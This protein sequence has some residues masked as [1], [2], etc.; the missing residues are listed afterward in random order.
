MPSISHSEVSQ[1]TTCRRKHLYGYGRSLK[2]VSVAKALAYGSA[3]HKVLEA[4]YNTVLEAGK[5]LKQQQKAHAAGV[6]A[7]LEAWD[8]LKDFRQPDNRADL[9]ELLFDVYFPNE[10]IVGEGHRIVAVEQKYSLRYDEENDL[11]FPFVV[12]LVVIDPEGRTVIVDHKFVYDFYS[13]EATQLMGQIPK[14][15]GA[16]RALNHKV[17]YGAY[18]ELRSRKLKN[19]SAEMSMDFLPVRPNNTRVQNTFL[20]QI[21]TASE[22]Q[23]LKTLTEDE[24]E[25]LAFRVDNKMVCN[26]CD[27]KSLCVAEQEGA[28]TKLLLATEFEERQRG[29]EFEVS[30]DA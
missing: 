12:D 3:G 2:P 26:F 9:H 22:I 23:N 6:D 8:N 28:S 30:E 29:E 1:Y 13:I 25:R 24:R 18:N 20:E 21:R 11:R 15:I 5:T 10:A 27:F 17:D 16:L 7:A 19:L 4:Y 14:Y